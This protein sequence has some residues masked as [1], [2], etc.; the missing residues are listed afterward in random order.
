MLTLMRVTL[1]LTLSAALAKG[2]NSE[3]FGRNIRA[4]K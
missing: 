3:I 1:T 4:E 2:H